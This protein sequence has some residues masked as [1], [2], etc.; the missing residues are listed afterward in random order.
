MNI[1]FKYELKDAIGLP[2]KSVT[3]T[4][5]KENNLILC[6]YGEEKEEK[7][8][9]IDTTILELL[10]KRLGSEIDT[11]EDQEIPNPPIL[12]GYINDVE[13]YA[14]DKVYK[15]SFKNL[16]YYFDEENMKR[17]DFLGLILNVLMEASNEV[18]LQV[19]EAEEY[20]I[21]IDE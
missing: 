17:R 8:F 12:D 4:N 14:N 1:I 6:S 16:D 18:E 19:E 5:E 15:Y 10:L 20:F 2:I 21:L 7:R 3:V 9:K 11:V 13:F